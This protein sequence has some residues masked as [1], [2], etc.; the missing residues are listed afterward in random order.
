MKYPQFRGTGVAL[1]TPFKNGEIDWAGLESVIEHVI[2]G[3]C[4][5]LVSLGS[6]G[7]TATLNPEESRQ[8]VDFTIKVNKGR[9][10]IVVG[11]F[12]L[13]DTKR[14]VANLKA[15]DLKDVDALLCSNPSYNKPTQEGIYQHYMQVVDACPLPII[16][17]NVPSRTGSNMLPET[18]VRLAK[19]NPKFIGIK[20]ATGDISQNTQIIKDTPEDF[21]VLSGDDPTALAGVG[22]GADGVISVLANAL[23]FQWTSMMRAGLDGDFAKAQQL[24]MQLFDLHHWMYVEGNPA[25]VKGALQLQG[26]TETRD[27]RLPLVN[28]SEKSLTNLKKEIEKCL[29]PS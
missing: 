24:N 16:L 26:I 6:T 10:P 9:L 8:I 19:E 25:G 18:V 4:D 23:P 27:V 2:K 14:L 13:N 28:L 7:E 5:F 22:C 1:V 12:G 29:Q 3:G 21:L 20:E 15:F 11:M 17:Y